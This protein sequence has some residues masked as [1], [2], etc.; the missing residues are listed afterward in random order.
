MIHYTIQLYNVYSDTRGPSKDVY[1]PSEQ[2]FNRFIKRHNANGNVVYVVSR[3][4][5]KEC[6]IIDSLN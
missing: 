1:A 5:C 3:K 2:A 4:E 6:L